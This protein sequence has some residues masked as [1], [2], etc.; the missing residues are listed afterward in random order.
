VLPVAQGLGKEAGAV[1][2][3]A[4]PSYATEKRLNMSYVA[5]EFVVVRTFIVIIIF[6]K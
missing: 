2:Q 4:C 3:M 1:Q 6:L 5:K